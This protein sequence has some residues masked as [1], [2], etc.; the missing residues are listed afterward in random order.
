MYN[1]AIG[2]LNR[3]LNLNDNHSYHSV[4]YLEN[5]D[6]IVV[7]GGEKYFSLEIID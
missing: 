3:L 2:E 5:F 1:L 6:S 4:E 7:V